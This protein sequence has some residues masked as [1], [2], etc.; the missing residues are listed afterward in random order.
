[1][2]HEAIRGLGRGIPITQVQASLYRPYTAAAGAS[3]S[4]E[5]PSR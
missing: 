5:N 3:C 1:M 2:P 4:T